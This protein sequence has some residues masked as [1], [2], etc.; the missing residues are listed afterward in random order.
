MKN[1][2][3]IFVGVAIFAAI[4]LLLPSGALAQNLVVDPNADPRCADATFAN[5]H[6]DICPLNIAPIVIPFFVSFEFIE[7]FTI[8]SYLALAMNILFFGIGLLWIGLV[9]KAGIDYI[10]SKGDEKVIEGSMTKIKSV[11]AS[12][13]ILFLSVALIVL[14]GS[15]L[16]LGNFFSW[17]KKLSQCKDGTLYITKA[18]EL[19]RT[20]SSGQLLDESVID[21]AC[22]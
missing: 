7:N 10:G 12:V 21:N 16:G 8:F 2:A 15:F 6:R 20:N 1:L 13:G 5:S 19:E 18:L 4:A 9:V 22:F 17:P 11:L 14:V 3:N